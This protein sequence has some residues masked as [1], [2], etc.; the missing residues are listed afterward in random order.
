[1]RYDLLPMPANFPE[2]FRCVM[3]RCASTA[4]L[5]TLWTGLFA[6]VSPVRAAQI[7][8]PK[9]IETHADGRMPIEALYGKYLSLVDKG[10]VL[11]LVAPSKPEGRSYS[12]PIIAL[13]TPRA[14]EATWIISGIHGEEPAGPN[15]I[16][17]AID[18]LA[19]LGEK[20]AVVLLPLNNPHGYANNWRYLNMAVY[21]E[22]ENGQ[23]VGDSS[24]LLPEPAKPQEARAASAS[25]PEVDAITRYVLKTAKDY[26]PAMSLDLHEDNLIH[27]G[28]VYSQGQLGA[29]DPLALAAV[30]A[31]TESGIPIKMSGETRFGEPIENGIIGPVVDSSIDELMSAASILV[32]G[33]PRPGPAARTVLVFETPAGAIPLQ[34]RVDAHAA[35]LHAFA[36]DP[37]VVVAVSLKKKV[38]MVTSLGSLVVEVYPGKAP[39]TA[40]NF[41]RYVDAGNYDGGSF[42]RVV[43]PDNQPFAKVKIEVIQG[44]I[45]ADVMSG[46]AETGPRPYP[47]I[48]HETTQATGLKHIDGAISMARFAPGS[49][50][51]EFFIVI[52][53][54]PALDF[55]GLR[56]PDGQGFAVFGRVVEGMDIVKRI[57]SSAPNP[58]PPDAT[59]DIPGQILREPVKILSM[60]R[61]PIP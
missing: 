20:R 52:G 8:L 38:D 41:L 33:E 35:L 30:K 51:S 5:V 59:N 55:G 2:P 37:R 23:S 60:K 26:P 46:R 28:Y 50:S 44:G 12:L 39:I 3:S 18:D 19:K 56:N 36:Q 17:A 61:R 45:L 16:A 34:R 32:H 49:A 40:S 48:A 43:R 6:G 54:N 9:G 4:V 13:R 42:Y 27:E 7:D 58:Q 11:D 57:Q 10:W 14:G 53:D 15:A 47:N 22:T 1:M 29:S 24:H 25:S 21:S 31:L